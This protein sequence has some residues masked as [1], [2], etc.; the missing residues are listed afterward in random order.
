MNLRR[1]RVANAAGFADAP[2]YDRVAQGLHWLVVGLVAIVIGLGLAMTAAPRGSVLRETL[3]LLHRSVG[4]TI[5]AAMLLR[6]GWRLGHPPPPLP[7]SV[8]PFERAAA[9]ANHYLLYAILIAMPLAGYVNAAAA[10]HRVSFFGF[11]A[12]PPLL[13]E[14]GRLAQQAIAAHL[15]GQYLVYLFIALHVAGALYHLAVKRD[16]VF[17]RMLPRRPLRQ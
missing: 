8:A 12:I 7:A 3:L 14:N 5:L 4:L 15:V 1:V 17:A 9:H 13:S 10:G 16:T 6:L 11:V 2:A